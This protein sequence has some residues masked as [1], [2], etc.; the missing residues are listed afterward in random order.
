[1]CEAVR[2]SSFLQGDNARGWLA[3]LD[4]VIQATSYTKV[5]EGSYEPASPEAR[6]APKSRMRSH[7]ERRIAELTPGGLE[8]PISFF[9]P[10]WQTKG[11]RSEVAEEASSGPIIDGELS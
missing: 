10:Q 3:D 1:M 8:G 4:F 11:D 9:D 7:A 6:S 5:L 2:R